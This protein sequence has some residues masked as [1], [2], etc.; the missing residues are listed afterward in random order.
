VKYKLV[1]FDFDGTLADSFPWFLG[2]L[3]DVADKY[4]FRRIEDH[5]VE[6]LR[7]VET[8]KLIEYLK[9]PFWK[10]PLIA[11]YM[12]KRMGQDVAAVTLFPGISRMLEALESAGLELAVV[13]SNSEANVRTVL[14][15]EN[16]GRIKYYACETDLLG[17][18]AKIKKVLRRSNINAQE[19][20]CIGDELRDADAARAAAAKFGAVVWGY[21]APS[22]LSS[23]TPDEIFHQV[24]DISRIL[25]Q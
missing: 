24:G 21:A 18:T 12:R 15:A 25:T 23:K 7:Q 2:V 13:T 22:A 3:N 4:G 19:T 1:I 5:E 14:G 10:M 9:I 20:I 16:A 11:R 17:K 6:L 8:R